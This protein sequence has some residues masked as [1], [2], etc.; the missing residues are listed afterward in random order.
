MKVVQRVINIA[1][2]NQLIEA[3]ISPLLAKLYAARGV[4]S[5]SELDVSLSN[6]IP[7]EQLTNNQSRAFFAILLRTIWL[8]SSSSELARAKQ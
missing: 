8:I 2:Q 1:V 5:A 7:P 3:G 6:L 4:M